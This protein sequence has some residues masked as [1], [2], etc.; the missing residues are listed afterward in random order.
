M[1]SPSTAPTINIPSSPSPA[2]P[3]TPVTPVEVPRPVVTSQN[4]PPFKISPQRTSRSRWL[5]MM[6]YGTYGVGK[7]T[8][9]GSSVDVPFMRDVLL[10]DAES[11]DLALQ[12]NPRVKAVDEIEHV[13]VTNFL[14]VARVQE[15]L[16]AHCV[17]R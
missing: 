7:S 4:A 5:K 11:G 16:K 9:M 8:L 13:R 10:I 12:D 1:A 14:M 2:S 6:I 3:I 15:F 17:R